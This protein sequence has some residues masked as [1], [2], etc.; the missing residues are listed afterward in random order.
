MLLFY[1]HNLDD[2]IWRVPL[3]LNPIGSIRFEIRFK[4]NSANRKIIFGAQIVHAYR[5]YVNTMKRLLS[6][7]EKRLTIAEKAVAYIEETCHTC[8]ET[9]TMIWSSDEQRRLSAKYKVFEQV[10][11]LQSDE[12][13]K[14]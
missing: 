12:E 10:G 2:V 4:P 3:Q 9:T 6:A 7:D 14:Q 8:I 13:S 11:T 5:G 1:L